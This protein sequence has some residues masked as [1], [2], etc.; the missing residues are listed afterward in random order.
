VLEVKKMARGT[1]VTTR[2]RRGALRKCLGRAT[3]NTTIRRILNKP[4]K[5]RIKIVEVGMS[6]LAIQLMVQ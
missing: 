6:G 1:K 5:T 4:L 3:N 2:A